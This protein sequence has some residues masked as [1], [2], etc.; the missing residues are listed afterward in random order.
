MR[1]PFFINRE[2]RHY[3]V[4]L[5]NRVYVD[6]TQSDRQSSNT[7]GGLALPAIDE[8]LI[9]RDS[10]IKGARASPLGGLGIYLFR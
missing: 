5:L 4:Q 10:S 7:P 3:S 2:S 6:D 8:L 1:P 9:P